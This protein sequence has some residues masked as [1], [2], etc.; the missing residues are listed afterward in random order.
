MSPND[1]VSPNTLLSILQQRMDKC[2]TEQ[3]WA[4]ASLSALYAGII[5]GTFAFSLGTAKW[6]VAVV[7]SA[8]TFYGVFF[9]RHRH[10][11]Y[12]DYRNDFAQLVKDC[13]VAPKVMKETKNPWEWPQLTGML[14]YSLWIL[15]GYVASIYV[16]F[17]SC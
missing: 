16:L 1:A 10:K 6:I 15:G 14:F 17:R 2:T 3:F 13:P 12:Y 7:L 5:S 8:A 4:V 9:V 11:G